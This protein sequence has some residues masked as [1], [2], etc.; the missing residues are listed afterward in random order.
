LEC[1]NGRGQLLSAFTNNL[2]CLGFGSECKT[3][4]ARGESEPDPGC[5]AWTHIGSRTATATLHR[6][7]VLVRVNKQRRWKAE[8]SIHRL[9]IWL[10]AHPYS[11]ASPRQVGLSI[12]KPENQAAAVALDTLAIV[13]DRHSLMSFLTCLLTISRM[14]RQYDEEV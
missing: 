13:P 12:A 11:R 1:V 4:N 6:I 3:L 9:E 5:Q 10:H 2:I 7:P 14:S 8:R